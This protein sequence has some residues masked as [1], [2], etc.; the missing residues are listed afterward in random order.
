LSSTAAT[1]RS[2]SAPFEYKFADEE[3]AGKFATEERVG[4]LAGFTYR[5]ELSW[6]IFIACIADALAVTL[7]TVSFQAVRTALLNPVKTLRSE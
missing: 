7:L 3:F 4:K 5:T 2:E 1:R 6:W